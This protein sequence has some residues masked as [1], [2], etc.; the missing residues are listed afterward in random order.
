MDINELESFKLSDAVKFHDKLNPALWTEKGELDSEVKDKLMEIARDFIAELG[1]STLKV[2]DI[3]ISGSNAAYTY[4]PHSDLDLHIL[5][6]FTKLPDDEVYQELFNAK[7]TLYND[8]HDIKVHGVPVELY[9]QDSNQPV[10]SLGEYSLLKNEWLKIPKKRK[11]NFDQSA[12]RLKYEKLGSLIELALKQKDVKKIDQVLKTIKRY[13]K[14]GLDTTG[15]FGPENLAFKALRSQGYIQKLYDLKNELH[16]KELSLQEKINPEIM[17]KDFDVKKIIEIPKVGKLTLHAYYLS[18]HILPQFKVDVITPDGKKV[19]YFRF[20][21]HDYEPDKKVFGFKVKSKLDPYVLA[22]NVSVWDEYQKKGIAT[23]VYQFVK[24]LGNDIKPSSTQTDAGKAMWRGF[25]KNKVVDEGASDNY[26]FEEGDCPIFAIALHKLTNLPIYGLVEYI[27]EMDDFALIHAYVKT[28]DGQVLDANGLTTVENILN[29]YPRE[30]YE[31]PQEVKFSIKDLLKIGYGG[32][33]CPTLQEILPHAKKL[34]KDINLSES[35]SG[36]IPSNAQKNDPRFKTALTVDIKPSTSQ[37]AAGKAMW[38]SFNRPTDEDYDPNGPPP[39]P[40]FK[41]TMPKGTVRVDVSDVYD[42]YKLGQHISNL[43]GLGKH[44]FGKGPPSTILSFGDED[45]EHKYIQDLEKTGLTTTDI[46]P[47]DPNQPKGM[48]RQKV[49]PTYN[50]NE[51]SG[52]IPSEKEKN[53]PRFKTALT[54]DVRPDSIK[55]NAKAFGFNVTR[56]GI[57]PLLRK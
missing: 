37:T 46:D 16:A 56:A 11:A 49:D 40:E 47:V 50:V 43:K 8:T 6:D 38:K 2:E 45:T 34:L 7:K 19:G 30:G 32:N 28:K 12:T 48:K 21:V 10:V 17:N 52:Y 39:G 24:E 14:A 35:A 29:T 31:E 41:P 54:K 18:D 9:V 5:V 26:D 36:Y 25:E 42:W 3:T 27:E 1:I 15:E 55:K 51:V 53:D 13:R 33:K 57:P 23:A 20:I 22:G 4:T 44:D